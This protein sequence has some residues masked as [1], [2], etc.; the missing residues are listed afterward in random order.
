MQQEHNLLQMPLK[1]LNILQYLMKQLEMH[2]TSDFIVQSVKLGQYLDVP[3]TMSSLL[4]SCH[5]SKGQ[6]Q[7]IDSSAPSLS[8]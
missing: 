6:L 3:H 1:I 8:L 7:D 5:Q 4:S 2:N